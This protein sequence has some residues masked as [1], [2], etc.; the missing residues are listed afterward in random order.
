MRTVLRQFWGVEIMDEADTTDDMQAFA[1]TL[2]KL[3]K[4][5]QKKE[6]KKALKH[7]FSYTEK[8]AAL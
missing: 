3:K 2:M 8:G 7:T 6:M 5:Q 1:K 4:K